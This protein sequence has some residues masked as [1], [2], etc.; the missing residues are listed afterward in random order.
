MDLPPAF[1]GDPVLCP[2]KW[3]LTK[4]SGVG[5]RRGDQR[6]RCRPSS[7]AKAAVGVVVAMAST[8]RS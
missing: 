6:H 5:L 4:G 1:A 2:A 8:D 7:L 3:P